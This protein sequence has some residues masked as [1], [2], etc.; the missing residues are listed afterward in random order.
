MIFP[1]SQ[2]LPGMLYD[3]HR[4]APNRHA[5]FSP[6]ARFCV[7]VVMNLFYQ[8]LIQGDTQRL[9]ESV[10]KMQYLDGWMIIKSNQ[11]TAAVR[12]N[13]IAHTHILQKLRGTLTKPMSPKYEAVL[14][15]TFITVSINISLNRQQGLNCSCSQFYLLRL[16]NQI[17]LCITTILN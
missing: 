15:S 11:W 6:R 2:L 13:G 3:N 17:Q 10:G 8:C 1:D 5:K 12:I 16:C 9:T 14:F 4:R 7:L